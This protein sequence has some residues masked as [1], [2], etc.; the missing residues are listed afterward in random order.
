MAPKTLMAPKTFWI[1]AEETPA[2]DSRSLAAKHARTT[3]PD[4]PVAIAMG[5]IPVLFIPVLE[6]VLSAS[7]GS[8]S[9]VSEL[10]SAPMRVGSN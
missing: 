6:D 9:T 1:A 8:S 5:F 3:R 2:A 10:C 4:K 7:R